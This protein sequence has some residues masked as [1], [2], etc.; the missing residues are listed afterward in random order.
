MGGLFRFVGDELSRY[1]S[2]S[3]AGLAKTKAIFLNKVSFQFD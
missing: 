1:N 2:R 3:A